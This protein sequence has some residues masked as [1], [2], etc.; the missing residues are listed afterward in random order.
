METAPSSRSPHPAPPDRPLPRPLAEREDAAVLLVTSAAAGHRALGTSFGRAFV[1][2]VV[3]A[4][5]RAALRLAAARPFVAAIVDLA[6][7]PP[8]ITTL[9]LLGAHATI[10]IVALADAADPSRSVEALDAGAVDVL[11]WPIEDR[12]VALL[13]ANVADRQGVDA[14]A[15]LDDDPDPVFAHSAPMRTV[16]HQ[17]RLAAGERSHVLFVG[18]PATGRRLLGRVLHRAGGGTDR[19]LVSLDCAGLPP[20]EI[21]RRLF[22]TVE[23]AG[24]A[25]SDDAVEPIEAESALGRARGGTLALSHLSDAPARVQVRLARVL[26]D[27]EARLAGSRLVVPLDVRIAT[28]AAADGA[29][30]PGDGRL[31]PDLVERLAEVRIDVPPLRRR[32]EDVP[33]LAAHLLRRASARHGVEPKRFSQS[34]M[35]VLAALPWHGNAA[36]LV[37]LVDVMVE[38]APGPV[39]QIGDVLAHAALDGLAAPVESGL[40]LRDARARFER[41]C[42]SAVLLR[43]RGRVGEAAKALGIQRTNLYRKVRQ[44]KVQRSLLTTRK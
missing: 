40:T 33:L 24:L 31:R 4:D 9:R 34:A 43:H 28:A 20:R 41:D 21:E 35:A 38:Q 42:I 6:D 11:A 14:D 30:G 13:L 12:D 27:R 36:D 5:A 1:A 17:V 8:A 23:D 22:G 32:R 10:P 3:A 19:P 26:R 29:G 44:L 18:E 2:T 39:V 7:G 16:M 37:A 25:A 15:A